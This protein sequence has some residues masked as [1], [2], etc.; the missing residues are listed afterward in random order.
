MIQRGICP[1][2]YS[3][4]QCQWSKISW[5]HCERA[6]HRSHPLVSRQFWAETTETFFET[7]TW[8]FHDQFDLRQFS[9]TQPACVPHIRR[10]IIK[11][12]GA[13][14]MPEFF[15]DWHRAVTWRLMRCFVSL[16]GVDI[17]FDCHTDRKGMHLN[18]NFLDD[19]VWIKSRLPDF[20]RALRQ[21]KLKQDMV[22]VAVIINHSGFLYDRADTPVDKDTIPWEN[23]LRDLL[24]Q[25]LPLG[26]GMT[27]SERKVL[28]KEAKRKKG[29]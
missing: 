28:E 13:L 19:M 18:K 7:S 15:K 25:H 2:I 3:Y 11:G 8:V 23:A 21:H 1:L 5:S 27:K 20:V 17:I 29:G 12:Q 4:D 24:L 22:S 6:F 9:N 14:S 10:L 26:Q 16:Q